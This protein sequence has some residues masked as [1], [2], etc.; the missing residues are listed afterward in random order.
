MRAEPVVAEDNVRVAVHIELDEGRL[1]VEGPE[2]EP[3]RHDAPRGP[4][5]AIRLPDRLG[6]PRGRG[7]AAGGGELCG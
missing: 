2:N 4:G 7:A 1:L 6:V 3:S 5:R